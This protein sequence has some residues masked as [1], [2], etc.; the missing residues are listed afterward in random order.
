M[1]PSSTSSSRAEL[2]R[3]LLSVLLFLA[4]LTLAAFVSQGALFQM[5]ENW[6]LSH[7]RGHEQRIIA[8]GGES[9]FHRLVVPEEMRRYKLGNILQRQPTFLVGGS[10]TSMQFRSSLF[11]ECADRFY[12]AGGITNST[13]QLLELAELFPKS[14]TTKVVFVGLDPWWF[15]P[16]WIPPS[17]ESLAT[18]LDQSEFRKDLTT[19][20][21]TYRQIAKIVR[22][23]GA[24]LDSIRRAF[25]Q[26]PNSKTIGLGA[27]LG[28]GFRGSDGSRRYASLWERTEFVD[29]AHTLDRIQKGTNRFERAKAVSPKSIEHLSS[30]LEQ[31][32]QHGVVVVGY[33]IP[34]EP[35]VF[36]ALT[37]SAEH[38]DF[39]ADYRTTM[40]KTFAAANQPLVDANDPSKWGLGPQNMVDGFHGSELVAARILIEMTKQP[41]VARAL[42]ECDLRAMELLQNAKS[43]HSLLD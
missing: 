28:D 16:A 8:E 1:N 30:F 36:R 13:A 39:F 26:E 35:Q 43:E 25:D 15:N 17:G 22:E 11:G 32:N 27:I 6:T 37:S 20:L 41:E 5:G 7:V 29:P 40:M 10:S 23:R 21:Q 31:A 34:L 42:G 24:R 14:P 18:L 2:K 19:N 9:L 3:F 4:P 38:K 12:N 33:T